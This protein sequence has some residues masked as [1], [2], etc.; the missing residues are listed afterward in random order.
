MSRGWESKSVESQMEEAASRRDSAHLPAPSAEEI[1]LATERRSLELSR[2]RVLHD[3]ES[4][5]HERR[6]QQ[7][8]AALD[9]LDGKLSALDHFAPG[10]RHD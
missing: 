3:L 1:R 5:T 7:L 9:Y 10:P 4:A 2:T 6:R 8:K